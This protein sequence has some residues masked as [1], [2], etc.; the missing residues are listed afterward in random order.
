MF[1]QPPRSRGF[2]AFSSDQLIKEIRGR[3]KVVYGEDDRYELYE[4]SDPAGRRDAEPVAALFEAS[5]I[6]DLEDGTCSLVLERYGER[7][8]LC[9]GEPFWQQPVGAF[10]TGFL[11]APDLI[12]TAG[13][14]L[15]VPLSETRVVFGFQM[16][17]ST[18]GTEPTARTTFAAGQVYRAVEVI[19]RN[20]EQD[21]IGSGDWALLRLDRPATDRPVARIRRSGTIEHGALVHVIGH[22][23]GLP[24]KYAGKAA[25]RQND[26]PDRFVANLD[27]Y[28]GNSGSPVYNTLTHE[29]EGI[30]VSGAPD[31]ILN[32]ERGCYM[33]LHCPN[34]P[35]QGDQV[36]IGETS[37]R[38]T[39]I[40]A[41]LDAYELH[42]PPAPVPPS[43]EPVPP[44]PPS[45]E[46]VPPVSPPN[47]VPC[48]PVPPQEFD[49]FVANLRELLRGMLTP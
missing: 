20:D 32:S 12:A 42:R 10:G 6:R 48:L 25:V 14:N 3:Q 5:A 1:V 41:A 18:S 11:V 4:V 45:P 8:Q 34:D 33:S 13:H 7:Y 47:T 17:E 26:A 23:R 24:I 28:G 39:E 38:I 36:C 22:P 40:V 35:S 19:A 49:T 29:V 31:F 16:L 44:V 2:E 30:L 15:R 9:K 27:A 46:P 43:P 21:G 37:T